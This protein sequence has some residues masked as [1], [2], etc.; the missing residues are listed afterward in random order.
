MLHTEF[1]L[2]HA[3]ENFVNKKLKKLNQTTLMEIINDTIYRRLFIK[4]IQK[5]LPGE[6]EST[7][8][9]K[10]FILCQKLMMDKNLFDEKEIFEKLI[11]LCPSFQWEQKIIQLSNGKQKDINFI[12]VL[13][14]LKWETIIELIC[15][16][17]YKIFL[18]A[19]K[20]NSPAIIKL[21][22]EI[23]RNYYF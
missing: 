6:R 2:D 23:F 7:M 4:F 18:S 17:D 5:I 20:R 21:L 8:L 15:H 3:M 10:R 19:I 13:E 11:E 9:L 12:H 14:N 16:N 1:Y 22:R